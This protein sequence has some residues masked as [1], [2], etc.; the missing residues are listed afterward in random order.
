MTSSV[1]SVSRKT[2]SATLVIQNVS[3]LTTDS[4]LPGHYF[5][6]GDIGKNDFGFKPK[7]VIQGEEYVSVYLINRYTTFKFQA[8]VSILNL[9]NE[10]IF[11]KGKCIE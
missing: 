10:K 3:K 9:K 11:T 2:G 7:D 6:I 1:N 8:N 5:K 4:L